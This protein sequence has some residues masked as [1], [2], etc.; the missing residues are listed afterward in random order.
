VFEHLK[1]LWIGIWQHIHTVTTTEVSPGLGEL[2]AEIIDD[3]S[4]EMIPVRY[5]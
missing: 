5:R 1:Q 3:V 4:V 2:L